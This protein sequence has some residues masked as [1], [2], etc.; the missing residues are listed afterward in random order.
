M[1]QIYQSAEHVIGWIRDEKENSY[2][3]IK[4]L[5]QISMQAAHPISW[6]SSLASIPD[7]WSGRKIPSLNDGIWK[8]INALFQ[9][10]WFRRV[11]IIQEVVLGDKVKLLCGKWTVDWD[12]IFEALKISKEAI[13]EKCC[14]ASGLKSLIRATDHT[15][16][17]WMI[18]QTYHH[19]VLGQKQ[20]IFSL[21][22]LSA[23]ARAT[24]E[25]DRLFALLGLASDTSGEVFNPDYDS[26]LETVVH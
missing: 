23:H 18:R 25:R 13:E 17:L 24:R 15:Q 22:E 7:S 1:R 20:D 2:G 21:L 4:T 10:E 3:A 26:P 14:S 8:D 6:P 19:G 5:L 12:D 11:W 16:A 9:R